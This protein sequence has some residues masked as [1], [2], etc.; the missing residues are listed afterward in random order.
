MDPFTIAMFGL[1]AYQAYAGQKQEKQEA[2][3]QSKL[4]GEQLQGI[5][6]SLGALGEVRGAEEQ[7]AKG[8]YEAGSAQAGFQQ[9][10]QLQS[11]EQQ[12][13]Q[14]SAQ[15]GLRTSAG[16]EE[17]KMRTT[18]QAETAFAFQQEGLFGQLGKALGGID[19]WYSGEKERLGSEATKLKYEQKQMKEKE[20]G[21]YFGSRQGFG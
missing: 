1:S 16:A 5:K 15:S 2:G 8:E 4:I 7:V 17:F 9:G 12:Y 20:K 13:Q 18:G 14:A 11:I 10:Q 3:M 6:K 21:F 19:Q